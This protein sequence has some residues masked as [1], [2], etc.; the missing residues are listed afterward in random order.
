MINAIGKSPGP[1]SPGAVTIPGI[2][3]R[4]KLRET[5]K[6][7]LRE[8]D[9]GPESRPAIGQRLRLPVSSMALDGDAVLH[10]LSYVLFVSG[11]I[12]GEEV[13][14]EVESAGRKHGRARLLQ[15]LRPSPHRVAPP[16]PYFGPCGGCAWQHI[17]YPEQ[18]RLK[19]KMLASV[20]ELA[21]GMPVPVGPAV[22]LDS[23]WGFRNKVHFVVG[24]GAGGELALGHY[25]VRSRNFIP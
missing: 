8:E 6:D 17:A 3:P 14:V 10:H 16:C 4:L 15:V 7:P 22:G 18:L 25:G 1:S 2:M 21:L 19:E 20:L 24:P 5:D 11:A 12:P 23:P 13:E 9:S